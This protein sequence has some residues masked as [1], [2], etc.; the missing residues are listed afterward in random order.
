MKRRSF[1]AAVAGLFGALFVNAK[2]E[3]KVRTALE[4]PQW[5]YIHKG[6]CGQV[7]FLMV[8]EPLP[9]EVASSRD[10]RDLNGKRIAPCSDVVCLTCGKGVSLRTANIRFVG[11]A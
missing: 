7:A 2:A 1:F 10:V 3:P 8:R 4:P 11:S 5:A 6:G 9:G